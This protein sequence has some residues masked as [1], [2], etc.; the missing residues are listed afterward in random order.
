M[1]ASTTRHWVVNMIAEHLH[2][3]ENLSP[4]R[5]LS[6]AV[7]L[8]E[9]LE[10]HIIFQRKSHISSNQLARKTQKLHISRNAKPKWA[11]RTGS[12]EAAD[13]TDDNRG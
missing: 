11:P 12:M 3:R 7:H 13:L 6:R 9:S 1:D 8:T 4:E 5:A 2:E 10:T